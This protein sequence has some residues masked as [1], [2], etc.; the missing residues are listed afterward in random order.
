VGTSLAAEKKCGNNNLLSKL[1]PAVPTTEADLLPKGD[2]RPIISLPAIGPQGA[3]SGAKLSTLCLWLLR[4]WLSL[5]RLL[6]SAY[7]H[8]SATGW[9]KNKVLCG[10]FSLDRLQDSKVLSGF[11]SLDQLQDSKVLSGFFSLDRL[12]DSKVLSGFFSLDRLQDSKV[13]SGFFSLDRL[14]D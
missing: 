7:T 9:Y 13:L 10:F 11:F 4:C 6:H 2:N 3:E 12:Q 1:N 8:A 5:D 14:Q